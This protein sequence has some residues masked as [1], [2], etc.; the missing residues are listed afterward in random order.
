[1]LLRVDI[2][3]LR[4]TIHNTNKL[5]HVTVPGQASNVSFVGHAPN[6]EYVFTEGVPQDVQCFVND[7]VPVPDVRLYIDDVDHTD[8][9]EASHTQDVSKS[10]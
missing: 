5:R 9:F 6:D 8:G 3:D 7:V 1:M 2:T 10:F 4:S